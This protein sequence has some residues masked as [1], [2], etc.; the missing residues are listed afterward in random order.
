MSEHTSKL[1]WA[2]AVIFF[3]LIIAAIMKPTVANVTN[4]QSD[5]LETVTNGDTT[6]PPPAWQP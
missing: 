3:F 6:T 4:S 1:V 5:R 2:A